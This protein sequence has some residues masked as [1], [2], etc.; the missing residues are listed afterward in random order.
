[1]YKTK[2]NTEMQN[3][4]E[5][6]QLYNASDIITKLSKNYNKSTI[7]RQ[8]EKLAESQFLTKV[9]E[10]NGTLYYEK[11]QEHDHPHFVCEICNAIKCFMNTKTIEISARILASEN[12]V[13]INKIRFFGICNPCKLKKDICAA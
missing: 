4:F 2:L 3:L 11:N 8:L 6:G 12:A 1:M 7:Y 10:N 5:A 13:F 9:T